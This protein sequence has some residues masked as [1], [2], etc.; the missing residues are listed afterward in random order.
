GS[1]E[2]SGPPERNHRGRPVRYPPAITF[3]H[4]QARGRHWRATTALVG[5]AALDRVVVVGRQLAEGVAGAFA[6]GV[7]SLLLSHRIGRVSLV[8]DRPQHAHYSWHHNTP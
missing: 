3:P 4:S 1:S 7:D 5:C 2:P 6:R 8:T